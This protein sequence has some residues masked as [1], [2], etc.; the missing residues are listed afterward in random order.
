MP[1]CV[2]GGKA[3]AS[4]AHQNIHCNTICGVSLNINIRAYEGI[5]LFLNYSVEMCKIYYLQYFTVNL[6]IPNFLQA[7]DLY[8]S[9][10]VSYIMNIGLQINAV[11]HIFSQELTQSPCC[12]SAAGAI[13]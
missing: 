11:K 13:T 5:Y 2:A 10:N 8:W 12:S 4:Y 6:H 7:I 3:V 1:G 9:D